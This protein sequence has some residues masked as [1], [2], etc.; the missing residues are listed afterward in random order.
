MSTPSTWPQIAN[1]AG[2]VGALVLGGALLVLAPADDAA[3][4]A[5]E[6]RTLA[7]APALSWAG[8]VDGSYTDALEAF[9]ADHFPGREHLM[10]LHFWL[11]DHRGLRD[12]Q[13]ALYDLE[14]EGG[15]GLEDAGPEQLAPLP[16]DLEALPDAPGQD[17]LVL[18]ATDL[19]LDLLEGD[20]E[21]D[22][23]APML[24]PRQRVP[25]VVRRGVLVSQ[26]RA[27]Q[28]FTAGPQ[29][30]PAYARAI[31]SYAEALADKL[32][33]YLMVIPTA[34]AFYL[35][36]DFARRSK[37]E[38][39]NLQATLAML[40]PEIHAV[41]VHAALAEHVD[42]SIYFRT[43]HHWTGRGAYY[44]YAAFCRA[45]GLEPVALGSLERRTL[46]QGFLGSLYR[47]TRDPQLAESPDDVEYWVP[48]VDT[49]VTR[50][51]AGNHKV[52]T[53]TRLLHEHG[54]GYGVFLG[55]DFPLMI[56]KTDK[57]P[58]RRAIL[59]KNSYGNA[60]ATFLPAHYEELLIVDYRSFRG[61]LVDL[62][63][64]HEVDD[65]IILNGTITANAAY[66]IAR[67]A[68]VLKGEKPR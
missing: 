22:L 48:A 54:Y 57:N 21:D 65:L 18:A 9:V 56:V 31:N 30:S 39:P 26:G 27:M 14:D 62:A 50:H 51:A 25:G 66:H 35:P 45:A 10:A 11:K 67:I 42:E 19:D 32:T 53:A 41:D 29:G 47:M 12:E 37:A 15:G 24:G 68:W 38:P 40:R 44:A 28:L 20:P 23:E 49:T 13:V 3:V 33:I 34:Q 4:S 36:E 16:D 2:F 8:L 55:G 46:K 59:L 64:E 61:S 17:D 6:N 63:V 1:V 5:D 58:G 60:F 7:A 52:F 43:D